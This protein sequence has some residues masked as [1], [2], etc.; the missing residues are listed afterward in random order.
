MRCKAYFIYTYRQQDLT[1]DMTLKFTGKA[2]RASSLA[3]MKDLIKRFDDSKTR[4]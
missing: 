3:Q 4:I 2:G 1:D